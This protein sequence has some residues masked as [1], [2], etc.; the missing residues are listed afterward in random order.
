MAQR[1]ITS[2]LT[3]IMAS[4]IFIPNMTTKLWIVSELYYPEVT[5]TGYIL[6]EIAEGLA[7]VGLSVSVLC[8]QPSYSMRGM[9][10]PAKENRNKV[11]IHRGWGTTLDK[12]VFFFRLINL[13]TT[14][15]SLFVNVLLRIKR[16]DCVLVVTNPP[17]LPFFVAFACWLR[18]ANCILLIHD[19]YPDLLIAVGKQNPTSLLVRLLNKLNKVLYASVNHIVVIGR[20]M[21]ANIAN[22]L[23]NKNKIRIITNWADI[24]KVVS[25]NKEQNALLRELGLQEKFVLEYAGNMGYPNDIESIIESASQLL[26]KCDIHF[27]FVGSGAKKGWLEEEVTRRQ[28]SNIT[29]LPSRSRDDQVNFLNA[30]DISLVSLVKGMKGISVPSRI[31]NILAAGKPIIALA[32]PGSE[33]AL[34]V[35]EEDIGWVVLPGDVDRLRT[36]I[37][38]AKTNL[39]LLANMGLRARRAAETKYSFEQVKKAYAGIVASIYEEVL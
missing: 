3:D 22:K 36:V 21:H 5:S 24:D 19:V 12:D 33:L 9:H 37:L 11:V 29:I 16:F 6:T 38:E 1:N 32:D 28:L 10:A 26:D 15:L 20:D 7:A 2:L 13:L 35:K 30:C 31:Y 14:T 17:L 4:N 23:D 27:L 8:G 34:V 25:I 18:K 39:N